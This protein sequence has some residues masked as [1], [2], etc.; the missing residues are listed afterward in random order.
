MWFEERQVCYLCGARTRTLLPHKS[1]VR[2]RVVSKRVVSKF[3][4]DSLSCNAT[5]AEESYDF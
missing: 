4:P 5:V 1:G 2:I 3:P